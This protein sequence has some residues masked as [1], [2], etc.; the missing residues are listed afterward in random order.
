M[1]IRFGTYNI[2]QKNMRV[3]TLCLLL[4]LFYHSTCVVNYDLFSILKNATDHFCFHLIF[5]NIFGVALLEEPLEY[6]CILTA[7]YLSERY[8]L[9]PG[10]HIKENI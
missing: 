9:K 5:F 8:L 10:K 1:C 6:K 7:V 4:E 3:H 2:F